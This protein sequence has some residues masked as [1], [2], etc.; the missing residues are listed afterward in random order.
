[1]FKRLPAIFAWLLFVPGVFSLMMWPLSYLAP[2]SFV[3]DS[4]TSSGISHVIVITSTSG[5][6]HYWSH[7]N[8]PIVTS[9]GWTFGPSVGRDDSW[10]YLQFGYDPGPPLY[11]VPPPRAWRALGAE[12][13]DFPFLPEFYTFA[14]PWSLLAVILL[15][16]PAAFYAFRLRRR[17]A[18]GP[19]FEVALTPP[20]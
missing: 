15:F 2:F 8:L 3:H 13:T 12:Y 7:I 10:S 1:M 18:A 4:P 14:I 16:Y 20:A 19:A 9:P 17:R 6:L 5:R 11:S